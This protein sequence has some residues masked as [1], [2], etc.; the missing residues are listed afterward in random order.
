MLVE[1]LLDPVP[2]GGTSVV[3]FADTP[4][5]GDGLLARIGRERARW[6]LDLGNP[7]FGFNPLTAGGPAA[8]LVTELSAMV[9]ELSESS[10]PDP[11]TRTRVR[12]A[13]AE[14]VESWRQGEA[15]DPPTFT[16]VAVRLD[17]FEISAPARGA[18]ALLTA[19][20]IERV[21]GHP[22]Q[23]PVQELT[24]PGSALV[25]VSSSAPEQARQEASDARPAIASLLLSGCEPRPAS[26]EPTRQA[27]APRLV[28]ATSPQ[29]SA[30]GR[31]LSRLGER[32][33]AEVCPS[34]A[35][36][37][38]L[39]ASPATR[40]DGSPSRGSA[41]T[42]GRSSQR[43]VAAAAAAE[44][45]YV[46]SAPDLRSVSHLRLASGT[47]S[48]PEEEEQPDQHASSATEEG[49][50]PRREHERMALAM[51]DAFARRE[52]RRQQKQ[53]S[54]TQIGSTQALTALA[55]LTV[56]IVLI[57]V[58]GLAAGI[59]ALEQQQNNQNAGG[60][61]WSQIWHGIFPKPLLPGEEPPVQSPPVEL[62]VEVPAELPLELI[63]ELVLASKVTSAAGGDQIPSAVVPIFNEA[64][65]VF[66]VNAFLLASVADQEST[67][68]TG[69]GW[70]TVNPWGCVGYM[71][72]CVGGAAGDSWNGLVTLKGHPAAT[73]P[74]R[75]AWTY[76]T[77]AAAANGV[78]SPG[79]CPPDKDYDDPFHA[80]MAAAA[81]LRSDGGGQLIPSLNGVAVDA[82]CR[83]Y[84]ACASPGVDYA[85]GVMSRAERWEQEGFTKAEVSTDGVSTGGV[86]TVDVTSSNLAQQLRTVTASELARLTLSQLHGG[87]SDLEAMANGS[88]LNVVSGV[89][90]AAF[91]TGAKNSAADAALA[92]ALAQIGK[93]YQWGGTGPTAFDCSGLTQA[94]YRAAGIEIPRVAQDQ[95]DAGPA[96]PTD[97]GLKPGDL[98]FFGQS[99]SD[100]T[101]VGMVVSVSGG[102]QAEMVD[103]PHTGAFVRVESFPTTVGDSW[104]EDKLIG[105]TQPWAAVGGG[106]TTT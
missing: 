43:A 70:T 21:L 37:Q 57:S 3:A 47:I 89:Q 73:F 27:P 8:A 20:P 79:S 92:F 9:F 87:L 96:A 49:R 86:S 102:G 16:E 88:G 17:S 103:A 15:H 71:Q 36:G 58:V 46:A 24:R 26:S 41:W 98:V 56:T 25:V 14:T 94:A 106:V 68:G 84:G 39:G 80:V 97:S 30:L 105:A 45:S 1:E 78:T 62:P 66:G 22:V 2:A 74:D 64:A 48:H 35:V 40:A 52:S 83:Y 95:Y 59:A 90:L 11:Y 99:A 51:A 72:T 4:D 77:Q 85:Q 32:L 67:F 5:E 31:H 63:P 65:R 42:A 18:F 104:G 93:P 54:R 101:H 33:G 76:D 7:E 34:A 23:I 50:R 13:I 10:T 19:Q 75:C 91:T 55:V 53:P 44:H 60:S 29:S 61:I 82:L 6:H 100:V 38:Y 81:E 69:P 28:L 12:E